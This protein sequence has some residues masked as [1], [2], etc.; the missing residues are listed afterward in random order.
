MRYYSVSYKTLPSTMPEEIKNEVGIN[1]ESIFL[2]EHQKK[3]NEDEI[4]V[5]L[6]SF[7]KD[8]NIF[9]TQL[10]I[11]GSKEISEKEYLESTQY[12]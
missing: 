2:F 7:F 3:L 1:Y 11:T 10:E 6:S 12:N 5:V 9:F 8:K 4:K